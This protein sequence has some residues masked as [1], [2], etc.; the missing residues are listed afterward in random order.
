MQVSG[1]PEVSSPPSSSPAHR[2]AAAPYLHPFKAVQ[3]PV[4]TDTSAYIW[5]QSTGV[6]GLVA[7]TDAAHMRTPDAPVE[8]QSAAETLA[9]L[10]HGSYQQVNIPGGTAQE[11]AQQ[12]LLLQQ[13]PLLQQLMSV[14]APCSALDEQ[15]DMGQESPEGQGEPVLSPGPSS[16]RKVKT[17]ISARES[18]QRPGPSEQPVTSGP[19]GTTTAPVEVE[20]PATV[21]ALVPG[22]LSVED[23]GSPAAVAPAG[24]LAGM[25]SSC[26]TM[27]G[28]LIAALPL[29]DVGSG[30]GSP[31]LSR[32]RSEQQEEQGVSI[33]SAQGFGSTQIVLISP[34]GGDEQSSQPVS[35]ISANTAPD[36]PSVATTTAP[37]P[38]PQQPHNAASHDAVLSV[39]HSS[40]ETETVVPQ[41]SLQVRKGSL[42]P[43]TWVHTLEGSRRS[44]SADRS[45]L[46]ASASAPPA[47]RPRPAAASADGT[48]PWHTSSSSAVPAG[49]NNPP[50]PTRQSEPTRGTGTHHMSACSAA[51]NVVADASAL[52]FNTGAAA[53]AGGEI[54]GSAAAVLDKGA[55]QQSSSTPS[56]ALTV[57]YSNHGTPTDTTSTGATA[58]AAQ[59]LQVAAGDGGGED[60]ST[61]ADSISGTTTTSGVPGYGSSVGL[62]ATNTFE[63]VSPRA[64]L[65]L[66]TSS[67]VTGFHGAHAHTSSSSVTAFHGAHGHTSS[68]NGQPLPSQEEEQQAVHQSSGKG[69]ASKVP[70]QSSTRSPGPKNVKGSKR[71]MP[72]G[73]DSKCRLQ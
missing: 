56:P 66:T 10:A 6:V 20:S 3:A 14:S 26:S 33:N 53:F 61:I 37:T 52:S 65:Q 36:A 34:T 59:Q 24:A 41:D 7:S 49:S 55:S 38:N 46:P 21:T 63:P 72:G 17:S 9:A 62:L 44:A 27:D 25:R 58:G 5:T 2:T 8:G 51:I 60:G 68:A 70:G 12:Q 15:E 19:P 64:M 29:L 4:G 32:D 47:P 54:T 1:A 42:N 23:M 30:E 40:P 39:N 43:K 69:Q 13:Q 31:L 22:Q 57:K 71:K 45:L 73:S 50:L 67:S 35:R 48:P 16:N 11:Q 28:S 18:E